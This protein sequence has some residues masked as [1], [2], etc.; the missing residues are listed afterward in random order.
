M[1]RSFRHKGLEAFFR[2][3]MKA[4]I[5]AHQAVK[6]RLML[7]ALDYAKRPE[8]MNAPGWRFHALL[9]FP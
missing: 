2:R 6:L 1:I 9:S 4:G 5:H 7:T 3:G 8:D